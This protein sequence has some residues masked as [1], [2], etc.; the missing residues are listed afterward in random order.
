[1]AQIRDYSVHTEQNVQNE[2]VISSFN[3]RPVE[4]VNPRAK[5][6]S[7]QEINYGN[8]YQIFKNDLFNYILTTLLLQQKVILKGT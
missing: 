5:P 7:P 1:M 8:L 2:K 4:E 3:D 6:L